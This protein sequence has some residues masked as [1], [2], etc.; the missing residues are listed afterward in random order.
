MSRPLFGFSCYSRP[1]YTSG[2]ETEAIRAQL[3]EL[4]DAGGV[5]E[6]MIT[7]TTRMHSDRRRSSELLAEA[8]VLQPASASS[9][10]SS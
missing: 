2:G 4:A 1:Q 10:S 3:T 5:R 9:T 6:I 8:F 7:G